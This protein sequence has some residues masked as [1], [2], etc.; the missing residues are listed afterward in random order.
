MSTLRLCP[1]IVPS[2]RIHAMRT[3]TQDGATLADLINVA[4]HN[5]HYVAGR[6]VFTPNVF[7][8]TVIER[9]DFDF[10]PDCTK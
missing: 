8:L 5:V 10:V 6:K 4:T 9:G 7:A 1:H 2:G 3:I